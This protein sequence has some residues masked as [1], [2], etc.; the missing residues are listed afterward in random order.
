MP[1]FIGSGGGIV[2]RMESV[3]RRCPDV[4]PKGFGGVSRYRPQECAVRTCPADNPTPG[5]RCVTTPAG[6]RIL[7][8]SVLETETGEDGGQAAG[9]TRFL[10]GV[11][12]YADSRKMLFKLPDAVFQLPDDALS[13]DIEEVWLGIR[14]I[15]VFDPVALRKASG[16]SSSRSHM[17]PVYVSSG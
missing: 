17:Y 11:C 7:D 16:L 2:V 1:D 5:L 6:V 4:V 15:V 8:C 3:R 14:G 13:S 10:A 12:I 9:E